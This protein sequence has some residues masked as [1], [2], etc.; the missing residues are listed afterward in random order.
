M[1]LS[2]EYTDAFSETER[3]HKHFHKTTYEL[4]SFMLIFKPLV[5]SGQRQNRYPEISFD[6]KMEYMKIRF[7]LSIYTM[8]HNCTNFTFETTVKL[9]YV[10]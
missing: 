8:Y 7:I 9:Y 5:F 10:M 2:W 3:K 4:T 6:Q 1:G